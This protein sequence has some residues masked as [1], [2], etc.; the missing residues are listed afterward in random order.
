MDDMKKGPFWRTRRFTANMFF[1]LGGWITPVRIDG[2][3]DDELYDE[4]KWFETRVV[5]RARSQGEAM[6]IGEK[7]IDDASE[8]L[9]WHD[10]TACICPS[11]D[12]E[13][14]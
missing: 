9:E 7:I 4:Q 1:E 6:E 13:D 14:E 12:M 11:G 3:Y 2:F 8:L 10:W 5:Y